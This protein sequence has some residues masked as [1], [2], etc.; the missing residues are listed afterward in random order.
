[1]RKYKLLQRQMEAFGQSRGFRFLD[2]YDL[3]AISQFRTTWKDGPRSSAKKLERL[4]S[5]FRFSQRRKWIE[6]NPATEL[7]APKVSLCPTMPY[8]REEMKRILAATEGYEFD[9]PHRCKENARRLRALILLLRFSGMRISDAIGLSTDRISGNR[10]FL[11]T[12]KTGV[13]V[14]LILPEVVVAALA[15]IP[16]NGRQYWFWSG[17]GKLDSAVTNWRARLQRLF[18]LAKVADG[19]AHRF[20]DTF[21]VEL[22]LAGV[23]IERV[24]ILLGH[25]SVR[26]TEKHYSPWAESRQAQLEG[27]LRNAW[28]NDPLSRIEGYTRGTRKTREEELPY[29]IG[30][31][32]GGAGGNR[33]KKDDDDT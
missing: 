20:R 22:L 31:I 6:E 23:P 28:K 4:R 11:Y 24:S 15:R 3:A 14:N 12:Q 5:F 25:Q 29:F 27:D 9:V 18:K 17:S 2:E 1:V 8:S 30:G 21:A 26:I 32:D 33:T 16:L 19:H 7:K 10:L 13:P